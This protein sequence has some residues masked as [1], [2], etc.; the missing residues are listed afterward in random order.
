MGKNEM[1]WAVGVLAANL[2]LECRG[3]YEIKI[4]MEMSGKKIGI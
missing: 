3:P 2:S 1:S 4:I